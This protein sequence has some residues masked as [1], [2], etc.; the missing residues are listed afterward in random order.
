MPGPSPRGRG[1]LRRDHGIGQGP[2]TIP[3][4]AGKP[5]KRC[6]PTSRKTDHPRAGG[7]N[8]K[9]PI[10][11]IAGIGTIPARAG[12]P[13]WPGGSRRTLG[14]HPRA[15]GETP[16]HRHDAGLLEGPSPRGRGNLA[17]CLGVAVRFGTIPA[18]AGKPSNPSSWGCPSW[19]HPRAG[20]ETTFASFTPPSTPGPS[21]RGRGNPRSCA[22]WRG[23]HGTIPARA[24]KPPTAAAMRCRRRDHPRAGGETALVYSRPTNPSPP[25]PRG[26]GNRPN[27]DARNTT[28]PTI[29]A[30]AG[31]PPLLA[32]TARPT[33]DHPRAGGE[34][35]QDHQHDG[36]GRGP[37]P[38]GRGNR[39]PG[40]PH[41]I[42]KGT[43]PARA[44]KPRVAP[45]WR[46]PLGDHPRAGGETRSGTPNQAIR[47]GPSPRGRGNP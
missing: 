18:R 36:R 43:I 39:Q 34:T 9:R 25:S 38:R 7:G 37:S 16:Q 31:K 20:G 23:V 33:R 17:A 32:L 19:D 10:S 2:G 13:R 6:G 3:A 35:R 44:G 1:N 26:R 8:H 21:P 4:R 47:S 46:R 42:S 28:P 11:T 22:R 41:P 15:G 14:D 5:L 27:G 45:I 30:R 40:Q 24:G 29:P 12:K